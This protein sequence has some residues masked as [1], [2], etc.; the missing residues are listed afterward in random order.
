MKDIRN[1]S[2][3]PRL[4]ILDSILDTYISPDFLTFVENDQQAFVALVVL[5]AV[6]CGVTKPGDWETMYTLLERSGSEAIERYIDQ[7]MLE[8]KG[9]QK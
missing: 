8:S 5:G 6:E 4:D 9:E 1:T 3:F 7:K 2:N